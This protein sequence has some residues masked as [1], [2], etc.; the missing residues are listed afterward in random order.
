MG[1]QAII[2]HASSKGHL[3]NV[4][5]VHLTPQATIIISCSQPPVQESSRSTDSRHI[6]I[7]RCAFYQQCQWFQYVWQPS[8]SHSAY[9]TAQQLKKEKQSAEEKHA[10]ED[11]K[12]KATIASLQ[13]Q[14]KQKLAELK[15]RQLT[16]RLLAYSRGI[17]PINSLQVTLPFMMHCTFG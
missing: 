14:K 13:Q 10:S 6:Y 8:Q 7:S 15:L 17:A 11:R 5:A 12:R 1:K 3:K 2:S 4:S 16:A 9:Q